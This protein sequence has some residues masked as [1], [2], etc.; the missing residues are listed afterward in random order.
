MQGRIAEPSRLAYDQIKA[1]RIPEGSAMLPLEGSEFDLTGALP[2]SF[3]GLNL[4]HPRS[5]VT[6]CRKVPH[7]PTRVAIL[8]SKGGECIVGNRRY[9]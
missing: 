8:I 1:A 5:K 9:A 7:A 2:R 3:S 6:V 4:Q